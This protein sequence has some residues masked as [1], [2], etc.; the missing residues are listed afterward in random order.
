MATGRIIWFNDFK[1][2]GFIE[3]EKGRRFLAHSSALKNATNKELKPGAKVKFTA[4]EGD[5][6]IVE[7]EGLAKSIEVL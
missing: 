1:G 5:S 7:V 3:D 6:T 4:Q 2:Y